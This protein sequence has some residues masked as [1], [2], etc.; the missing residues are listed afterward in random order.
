METTQLIILSSLICIAAILYSSVGHGGAS[1]YIAIMA[2]IGLSPALIKPTGLVL[3]ILVSSIAAYRFYRKGSF[4][5]NVFIPVTLFAMPFS[6]LG[7]FLSL[8]G[9]VYKII[10]GI[11]LVY[12]AFRFMVDQTA[13]EAPN[14]KMPLYNAAFFGS[15]IGFL[16]GL[17]GVGG[18]IFLSPLLL[19]KRWASMK[20]TAGISALF[21]LVNSISGL[22]GHISNVKHLPD[23]LGFLVVA[24]A[25][26]GLIGSKIGSE[27]A[28]I[29]MIRK[30]LAVVIFIA[31]MKLIFL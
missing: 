15:G 12:A 13:I 22:L 18:G 7:G 4:N 14:K 1:G 10:A 27:K 19:W 29:P 6:F 30:L 31:G 20:E 2:L 28:S 25:V 8:S 16:S 21:I 3:N 5:W 11:I 17:I 23:Y 26:G 24:A 9:S